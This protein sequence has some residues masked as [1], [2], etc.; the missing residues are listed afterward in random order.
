[1]VRARELSTGLPAK[2]REQVRAAK[3]TGSAVDFSL[4]RCSPDR[5][6][7]KVYGA[8]YQAAQGRQIFP[9][10]SPRFDP[11]ISAG[12]P[13]NL[14][15][16][17]EQTPAFQEVI[18]QGGVCPKAFQLEGHQLPDDPGWA[19]TASTKL[20]GRPGCAKYPQILG[21]DFVEANTW[22]V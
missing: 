19:R 20:P 21:H 17:V 1:M 3:I 11:A 15:A 4:C 14:G 13:L 7:F 6:R 16:H 9:D 12:C 10:H 2:V 18:R 8:I 5:R 22:T